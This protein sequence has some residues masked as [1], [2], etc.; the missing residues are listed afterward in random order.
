MSV[1][2][3]RVAVT[4]DDK[5]EGS[6]SSA[7][8]HAGFIAISL[9][10]LI[11]GPAPDH[12][13]LEQV[14]RDLESFDWIICASARAVRA[15]SEARGARWPAQPRTA[16]VGPVT[17]SAMRTAGASDPIVADTF[18]ATALLDTLR[19]LDSWRDRRVL[20]TTVSEGRRDLIEGLRSEGA[21][22]TELEGA[23]SLRRERL[24]REA[25]EEPGGLPEA[26]AE[27]ARA[28]REPAPL[29]VA[30]LGVLDALPGVVLVELGGDQSTAPPEVRLRHR[31]QSGVSTW[32]CKS[33]FE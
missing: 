6:V 33:S 16:A 22:V 10:M 21:L 25:G 2:R 4:R 9:P 20:I 24:R 11:E 13:R 12:L 27:R 15:I 19:S 18:T 5:G 7:L 26:V 31:T 17:A 3:W 29:L 1:G 8:E 32:T 23:H 28:Y 30:P 14:A